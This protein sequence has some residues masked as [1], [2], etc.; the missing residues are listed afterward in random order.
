MRRLCPPEAMLGITT[1]YRKDILFTIDA[2]KWID[3]HSAI[4][5]NQLT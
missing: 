4:V 3:T 1:F 5:R 2:Q